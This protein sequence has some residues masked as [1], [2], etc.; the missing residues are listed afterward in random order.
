MTL[1]AVAK[2]DKDKDKDEREDGEDKDEDEDE[3]R[4]E[5]PQRFELTKIALCDRKTSPHYAG[6]R[7]GRG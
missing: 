4:T 2:R 1:C 7:R 5:R 3:G 6:K